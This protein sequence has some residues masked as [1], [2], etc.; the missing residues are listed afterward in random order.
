LF[1]FSCL[2]IDNTS[3]EADKG[4]QPTKAIASARR[5]KAAKNP[6]KKLMGRL[7]SVPMLSSSNN[8]YNKDSSL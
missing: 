3:Q 8:I 7:A 5:A 4:K 2:D 6:P 1:C